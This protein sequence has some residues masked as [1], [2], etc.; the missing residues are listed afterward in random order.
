MLLGFSITL[1]SSTAQRSSSTHSTARPPARPHRTISH[2]HSTTHC[3]TDSERPEP[4]TQPA[5]RN[6]SRGVAAILFCLLT[7]IL[8]SLFPT[9]SC[10]TTLPVP[11]V[12]TPSLF[13]SL[14][15]QATLTPSISTP[16]SFR[17]GALSLARAHTLA[18]NSV[19]D[20]RRELPVDLAGRNNN[21]ARGIVTVC[22][23]QRNVPTR[24]RASGPPLSVGP[25]IHRPQPAHGFPDP[26]SFSTLLSAP[27]LS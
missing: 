21:A 9:P 27:S 14:I 16:L 3:T 13:L 15:P 2:W 11:A 10:Q 5:S 23:L 6:V 1:T 24:H 7:L 22:L 26:S 17:L 12:Y 25:S 19:F 18:P 4:P 8:A 20:R